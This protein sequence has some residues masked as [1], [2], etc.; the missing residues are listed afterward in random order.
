M[1]TGFSWGNQKM[2]NHVEDL[3]VD[4]RIIFKC[5]LKKWMEWHGLDLSV[6]KHNN[7]PSGSIT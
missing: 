7:A 2:R 4:V 3:T 6:V 1:R 5:I